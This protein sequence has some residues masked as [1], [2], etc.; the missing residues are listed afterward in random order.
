MK[1]LLPLLPRPSR[2]LG[3]EWGVVRKDPAT[4]R[5]RIALAFPD[6]YEMGMS[7][8]GQKILTQAINERADLQAERVFS[9]CADAAAILRAHSTPLATLETDT[10]LA[11]MD[12]VG[13]SLTHELC[14]TNVLF[15]L[16]LAQIP[17][18]AAERMTGGPST[19]EGAP[20]PIIMAGGGA[21][22]NAEPLAEFL[23]LLVL[24]DGEEVMPELVS[25]IADARKKGTPREELLRDLA[26]LP[27][28]YV[29]AF[30]AWDG[31]GQPVRPL[32][33]GYERVEKAIVPDL[34]NAPF[35]LSPAVPFGQAV[36]DRYTIELARGCTR[37]CRF[38][39]AGMVYR[40]VREKTPAQLGD[41]LSKAIE[42]TGFE[43]VSLLS[44]STGDYSALDT[45]FDTV[46]DRCA[47]EQVTISLPSLRVGSLSE[48]I[49]S[50]MASIR[51]TGVTLAPEAGSQRLRDVINKGVDEDALIAHVRTLFENG[52][53]QVKLYFMLGLPTETDADLDAIVDLCVKVR[54]AAGRHVKRLQV[55]A[56]V[57]PFVPK[58]H[59]PFQWEGQISMDEIRRR[60]Y[61]LKDALKPYKRI[62]LKYHQPEMSCLE[63][64]FSRGDRRLGK[65]V[66]TAYRKGALFSSWKDHLRLE[67]Y[68]EALSEHGLS[69][70]EFQGPR[71]A[72]APL[73]WDHLSCGV[74]KKFLLAERER[75]L[76]EKVTG[77]CRYGACR[78]CGVCNMDGRASELARQAVEQDIRPRVVFARRDQE[79]L[80]ETEAASR[81]ADAQ[82]PAGGQTAM[83][84]DAPAGQAASVENAA[85]SMTGNPAASPPRATPPANPPLGG[86]KPLPPDL[87]LSDRKAQY[88]IWYEKR[89][90]AAYLSQLELQSI[91]ERALR[92][93]RF[94][95]SFS[96]GF[97]PMPRISF[98]RALPVGVESVSEWFTLTLREELKPEYVLDVLAAQMPGGLDPFRIETLPV[99]KRPVQAVRETYLLR[100][101]G[102]EE[103]V[104]RWR[105]A[106]VEFMKQDVVMFDR[107]SKN[108]PKATNLR[109]LVASAELKS[110]GAVALTF[111]WSK[112]YMSPQALVLA[113]GAPITP[114]AAQ[115]L[116]V[117]QQFPQA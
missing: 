49:I 4:V 47:A 82:A 81:D 86:K 54:D 53:Q 111:D 13:F 89:A 97:H 91:L 69:P 14:Y 74:S 29:P 34:A 94:P 60:I 93:T 44:L 106:W 21:S 27:G 32:V 30:F 17:L 64:V 41:M 8:L 103:D 90:E 109:G 71:D 62:T 96:A 104:V 51:R 78:S 75:A 88:R 80:A 35:P 107:K 45:L 73:P 48:R 42:A 56:A 65:V 15:M 55:T 77:D 33:P 63:G 19:G 7:Y 5:G 26:H 84:H 100:Y 39:H 50:R 31:P 92:R 102:T 70:E 52:W 38:C 12:A 113:V 25:R 59:T 11:H 115:L 116:K 110:D 40:P 112:D 46:F 79:S 36:H 76:A 98:G 117:G 16:D 2:Y 24:G 1:E 22:Y 9:P 3:N 18:R 87:G 108:G 58:T 105:A 95:L 72:A 66:E 83:A 101:S 68:L 6:M 61:Y 23:D 10:P 20:W 85:R 43:E 114:L 37:G 99:M 57:S 67:H 28:V